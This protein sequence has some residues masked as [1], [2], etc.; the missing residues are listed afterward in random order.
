MPR[1]HECRE[2]YGTL[3][4]AD[5]DEMAIVPSVSAGMSQLA[6]CLDFS[7]RPKVVLTD[8]DFPTNHYVWLAQEKAGAKLDVVRSPDGIRIDIDEMISRI[9][10][11]TADRQR[12]SRA[13]RVVLHHGRDAP[14]TE[15]AHAV[16][17]YVVVDDFHGTGVLPFDVHDVG[18]RLPAAA[19]S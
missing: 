15:A 14:S 4:G 12:Q 3:I 19:E 17:A 1:L 16:G 13:V 2:K 9:D 5:A 10:E 18:R 6:T 8:M 11:Q 7:A